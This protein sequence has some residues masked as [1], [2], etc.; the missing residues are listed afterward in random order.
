MSPIA[1]L[2]FSEVWSWIMGH[3]LDLAAGMAGEIILPFFFS[4]ILLEM[5]PIRLVETSIYP[6]SDLSHLLRGLLGQ[7]L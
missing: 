5:L 3:W 6:I 7:Q 4:K 1:I 2:P